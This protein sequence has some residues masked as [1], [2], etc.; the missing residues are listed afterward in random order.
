MNRAKEYLSRHKVIL[1]PAV[2]CLYAFLKEIK[3]GEPFIYKYQTEFLNFTKATLSGDVYPF[4]AYSYLLFLV[5]IFLF[6]DIFLYKPTMMLEMI[7]QITLRCLL[8]FGGSLLSQQLAWVCYGIASASEIAFFAYI[9]A[10]LNK[11][12]YQK[13]TTWTR[14]ATMGGRCFGYLVA[15]AILLAGFGNYLTLNQ[16]ALT[17]PCI[18]FALCVC[19]PRVHWKIMVS[20][21]E[22]ARALQ[23]K[24]K[25]KN[26]V[27]PDSY[28]RY[29]I[30]RFKKI[31]SD[32]KKIYSIGYIRKWSFWWA[33]TT[34]MSLQVA[35]YAQTLWGEV[36][37][38]NPLNGFAEAGYT[39]TAAVA[40]LLMNVVPIDWD[41]YGEVALVLISSIDAG[42]LFLNAKT[43]NIYVMYGCYIGY[44]SL[45]Q[46]M[47][48]IAQWN[49][50]KKMPCE[51]YGLVFG[52]N[53]FIALIMQSL[54]TAIVSDKRGLGM[55][56]RPQY[57]V[58]A[59]C[60]AIIAVIF[61]CSV[62]YNV[63]SYYSSRTKISDV[64]ARKFSNSQIH[65]SNSSLSE[66]DLSKGDKK[67]SVIG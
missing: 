43:E 37:V 12:Q 66:Q 61:F 17:V 24:F 35:L 16:I 1:L 18:V 50:A 13:L 46:V 49:I 36:S 27:A 7:G 5:P 8:V 29:V 53:S 48:T 57:M 14:A 20:R 60:H 10:I 22:E 23:N 52:V 62:T 41:K 21:M 11:E 65:S 67:L 32:F 6:T 39:F 54:I 31:R 30:Y 55:E 19:L 40:I 2:L 28:S 51:S 33:M 15:Q 25:T 63:V 44:R 4:S 42:L 56:V 38:N 34:C 58:Y 59:C 64:V 9:Y 45:Y 3:I 47:I 26:H